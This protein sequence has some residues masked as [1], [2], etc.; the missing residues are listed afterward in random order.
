LG[1]RSLSEYAEEHSLQ[2]YG[3]LDGQQVTAGVPQLRDGSRKLALC[4]LALELA[5]P[6]CDARWRKRLIRLVTQ[7]KTVSA[8]S[9]QF[10]RRANRNQLALVDKA[11]A[12]SNA[13]HVMQ[14]MRGEENCAT[15][16]LVFIE[17]LDHI[18]AANRVEAG[19]RL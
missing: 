2:R 3:R 4:K 8:V 1:L 12:V 13:L 10:A 7:D 14:D 17:D 6:K 11:E 18:L 5:R 16:F 9:S 19:Q 15:L